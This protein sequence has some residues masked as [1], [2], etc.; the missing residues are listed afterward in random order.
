M[1]DK[2][3]VQQDPD[4]YPDSAVL[5]NLLNIEDEDELALAER[6]FTRVRAEHFEPKFDQFHLTYLKT[7]HF[8]LFQDIYPWAGHIRRVDI[9]KGQTRFCHAGNIEREAERLFAALEADA[10]LCGLSFDRFIQ[11]VA[12]YYCELNVIHPFRE[13][14]GRVQRIFFEILALNAGYEICWEG[15]NLKEWVAAN[16]AGYFGELTPLERLFERITQPMQNTHSPQW[17]SSPG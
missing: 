10:F 1:R 4:C 16:Q 14:N 9:T 7:I 11:R 13:G 2:Y 12:H 17:A 3:G 15:I 6:D 5:I 8:T